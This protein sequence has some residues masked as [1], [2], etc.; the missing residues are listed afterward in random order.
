MGGMDAHDPAPRAVTVVVLV[1]L[2]RQVDP[3]VLRRIAEG[4]H[5]ID[6]FLDLLDLAAQHA[7]VQRD[8]VVGRA[9]I[10]LGAVGDGAL[11]DPRHHVLGIDIVQDEVA[12]LVLIRHVVG[13]NLVEQVRRDLVA[14]RRHVGRVPEVQGV[15][16]STGTRIWNA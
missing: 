5:R 13:V 8:A 16:S 12:V 1:G 6:A 7:A 3:H 4:E 9:E 14:L 15:V 2:V 11:R 10:L